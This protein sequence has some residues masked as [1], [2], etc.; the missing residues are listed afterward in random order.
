MSASLHVEATLG[1]EIV[2][3]CTIQFLFISNFIW[4]S[5]SRLVVAGEGRAL[6]LEWRAVAFGEFRGESVLSA[7]SSFLFADAV[8]TIAS[9]SCWTIVMEPLKKTH[10]P[11]IWLNFMTPEFIKVWHCVMFPSSKESIL[12][13]NH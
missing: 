2:K 13:R 9:I 3:D 8:A 11:M 12:L 6:F 4:S 10:F 1:V 5:V 7:G